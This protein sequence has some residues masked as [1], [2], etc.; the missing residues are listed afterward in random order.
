[1]PPSYYLTTHVS[2]KTT[3]IQISKKNEHSH[4]NTKK[5]ITVSDMTCMHYSYTYIKRFKE[6]KLFHIHET[7]PATKLNISQKRI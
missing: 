4:K 3:V 7:S 2:S 1:M 6:G 5:Q